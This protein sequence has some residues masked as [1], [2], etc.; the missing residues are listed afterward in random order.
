VELSLAA[1]VVGGAATGATTAAVVV[2]GEAAATGVPAAPPVADAPEQ[3]L[4][5]SARARARERS[6]AKRTFMATE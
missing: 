2:V 1:G 4:T 6:G 3:A 5:L